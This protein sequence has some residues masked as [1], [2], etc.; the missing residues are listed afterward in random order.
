[1][2][3]KIIIGGETGKGN[4]KINLPV[5]FPKPNNSFVIVRRN[6]GRMKNAEHARGIKRTRTQPN[7]VESWINELIK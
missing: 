4:R 3:L 2:P 5:V 7:F 6:R 1:M